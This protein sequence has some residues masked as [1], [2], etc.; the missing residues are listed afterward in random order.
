M[1]QVWSVILLLVAAAPCARAQIFDGV[2]PPSDEQYIVMWE[3][4]TSESYRDGSCLF[5]GEE[6][7]AGTYELLAM[8][9]DSDTEQ[10]TVFPAGELTLWSSYE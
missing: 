7:V 5:L 6:L 3:A 8:Q 9:P 1:H 4:I 2:P 10:A